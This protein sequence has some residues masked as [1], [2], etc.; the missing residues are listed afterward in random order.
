[1]LHLPFPTKADYNPTHNHH[2]SFVSPPPF[3]PYDESERISLSAVDYVTFE[4]LSLGIDTFDAIP[5]GVRVAIGTLQATS[6][7]AAGLVI[8]SISGLAPSLQ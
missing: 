7:R 1:M 2:W 3:I 5:P 6:V 4:T 8:T